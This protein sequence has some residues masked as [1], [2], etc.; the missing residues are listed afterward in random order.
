MKDLICPFCEKK[1]EHK[2]I[3]RDESGIKIECGYCKKDWTEGSLKN[4]KKEKKK[5]ET[6]N[7]N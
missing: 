1:H 4:S 6:N 2:E 7:S 3:G 5:N